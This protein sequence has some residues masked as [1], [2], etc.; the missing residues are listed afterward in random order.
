MF[1]CALPTSEP[2][3]PNMIDNQEDV[4]KYTT[5]QVADILNIDKSTLLRWIR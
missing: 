2:W 5:K 1:K 3:N 4:K